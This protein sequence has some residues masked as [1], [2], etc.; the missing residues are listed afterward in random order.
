MLSTLHSVQLQS[1]C[2][3]RSMHSCIIRTTSRHVRRQMSDNAISLS[4]KMRLLS[5]FRHAYENVTITYS[6]I[7]RLIIGRRTQKNESLG[8][9]VFSAK[10][11]L[12][13]GAVRDLPYDGI[14]AYVEGHKSGSE[15][16][17]YI[18]RSSAF[19]RKQLQAFQEHFKL[20][21]FPWGEEKIVC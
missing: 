21:A 8:Y 17:V 12:H 1:P 13:L 14:N 11:R 16:V 2:T 10:N 4:Y 5:L 9:W 20:I 7:C 18:R 19:R 15:G 3:G 6:F